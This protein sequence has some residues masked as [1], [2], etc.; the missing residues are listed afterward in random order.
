VYVAH[1]LK[2]SRIPG[3]RK[4]ARLLELRNILALDTITLDITNHKASDAR[5]R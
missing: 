2:R 4:P 5:R 1:L 3:D